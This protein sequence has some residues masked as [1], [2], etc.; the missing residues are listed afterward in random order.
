MREKSRLFSACSDC[1]SLRSISTRG[2]LSFGSCFRVAAFTTAA[3]LGLGFATAVA[4]GL[5]AVGLLSAAAAAGGEDLPFWT[6]GGEVRMA[7]FAAAVTFEFA[8]F[9]AAVAF[10]LDIYNKQNSA[11]AWA[12][13]RLAIVRAPI[14]CWLFRPSAALLPHG[15]L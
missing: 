14:D 8:G 9:A 10:L 4:V 12:A 13:A 6:A 3:K 5:D 15:I 1:S 11:S 7:G 2:A